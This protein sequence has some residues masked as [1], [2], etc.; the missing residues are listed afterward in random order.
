MLDENALRKPGFTA[1]RQVL[2]ADGQYWTLPKPKLR[3]APRVSA[4]GVEVWGGASFGPESDAL[5]DVLYGVEPAPSLE[6]LRVKFEVAVRLLSA[7]YDLKP[8]D[9]AQLLVLE[10]GNPESEARWDQL[11]EAVTGSPPK[12]SPAI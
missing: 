5:L 9:F 2:M 8:Q 4:A 11:G 12:P 6:R 3:F 7:N 10:P 1:G